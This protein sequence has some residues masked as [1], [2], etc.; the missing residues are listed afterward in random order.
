MG[1]RPGRKLTRV[2]RGRIGSD[3]ES[4]SPEPAPSRH[5]ARADDLQNIWEEEQRDDD[6]EE[7]EDLEDFIVD[8]GEEGEMDEEERK[9]RRRVE[10]ERRRAMGSRPD[11]DGL[12]AA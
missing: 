11:M 2:R 12:D 10:R 5:A 9:E 1:Y 4:A 6:M 3:D 8:E 7:V